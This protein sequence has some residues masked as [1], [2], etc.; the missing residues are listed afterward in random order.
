MSQVALAAKADVSRQWV[1]AFELGRPGSELRLILR[2]LEALELRLS[3]EPL[4]KE[5][6][7]GSGQADAVDLDALLEDHREAGA[8]DERGR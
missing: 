7:G 1:S 2:V 8:E 5:P 4:G 3:V 6:G